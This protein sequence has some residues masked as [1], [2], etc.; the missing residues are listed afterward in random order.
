MM[1]P[2]AR[3][4]ALLVEE[5]PEET[6][7]YDLERHRAH[8]LNRTAAFVWRQCDGRTSVGEIATWL[9]QEC[10]CPA[11]ESLVW[12]AL[13]RLDRACLLRERLQRS[14]GGMPISRRRVM[15]K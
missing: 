10:D 2:Q 6:L 7:V 8:R 14:P 4:E 9:A 3:R 15:Q 13:D 5:L 11:D 1:T 12:L